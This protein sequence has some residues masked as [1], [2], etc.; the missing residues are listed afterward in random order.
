M[1]QKIKSFFDSFWFNA[2]MSIVAVVA[3]VIN[4]LDQKY[5]MV[6]IWLVILYHFID[7]TIKANK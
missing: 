3:L 6:V 4:V 1:T 2:I 5:I 7:A